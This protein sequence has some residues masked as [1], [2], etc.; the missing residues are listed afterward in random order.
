M[1]AEDYGRGGRANEYPAPAP[2]STPADKQ[3]EWHVDLGMYCCCP[4]K[5]HNSQYWLTPDVLNDLSARANRVAE[6]EAERDELRR[7]WNG[8]RMGKP[9]ET[10]QWA[11]AVKG[12]KDQAEAAATRLTTA[13]GLLRSRYRPPKVTWN[14]DAPPLNT[15]MVCGDCIGEIALEEYPK[16]E[17]MEALRKDF[18]HSFWC[19]YAKVAAYLAEPGGETK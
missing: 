18:P 16:S 3:G 15:R 11:A 5:R 14:Q 19:W 17:E 12:W 6:L 13:D 4:D 2:D 7:L 8:A 9:E 1:T 10:S